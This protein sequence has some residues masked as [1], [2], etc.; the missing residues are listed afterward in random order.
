MPVFLPYGVVMATAGA[1][2][3]A[4]S[5]GVPALAVPLFWLAVAQAVWIAAAALARFCARGGS[6]ARLRALAPAESCACLYTVPLGIAVITSDAWRLHAAPWLGWTSLALAWLT[7]L[8]C[9]GRFAAALA[10]YGGRLRDVDG[11]WFLAPAAA[12][13]LTI[14]NVDALPAAGIAMRAVLTQ[15]ALAAGA[16]GWL[17]YWVVAA[18]AARRVS[19]FGL[20][21]RSR[22]PWWIASGCAGLAA[23]AVDALAHAQAGPLPVFKIALGMAVAAAVVLMV[24]VLVLSLVAVVRGGG[25]RAPVSW[26]PTFS[27]VVFAMGCLAAGTAFHSRSFAVLGAIASMA[28]L[29]LWAATMGRNTAWMV[30][31]RY[32]RRADSFKH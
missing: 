16:V 10:K 18:V 20:G 21:P 6:I 14:A 22:A 30:A 17:S 4:P 26:T 28:T 11:A 3:L 29:A 32:A 5:C 9:S 23:A 19:R 8:F 27:T 12:L 24:P 15:A 1:S 25:F 7:V 13:G 31:R 2:A